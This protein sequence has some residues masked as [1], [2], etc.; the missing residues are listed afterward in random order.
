MNILVKTK[1]DVPTKILVVITVKKIM[2]E[3]L[4]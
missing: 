1:N 4:T 3:R 2:K